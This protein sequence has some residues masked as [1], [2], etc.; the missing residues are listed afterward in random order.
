LQTLLDLLL[1]LS[2]DA[3]L[4]LVPVVALPDSQTALARFSQLLPMLPFL[5]KARQSAAAEL[6]I[7]GCLRIAEPHVLTPLVLPRQPLRELWLS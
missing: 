6:Y 1:D 5:L 7:G 2:V 4:A 3:A